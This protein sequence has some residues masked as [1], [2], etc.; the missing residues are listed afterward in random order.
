[1]S[2]T[3]TYINQW[4]SEDW[5]SNNYSVN[6]QLLHKVK[7]LF[8]SEPHVLSSM[9]APILSH[10]MGGRYQG[11]GLSIGLLFVSFFTLLNLF[12]LYK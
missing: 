5:G 6:D 8:L 7:I 11:K 3:T 9:H 2:N 4:L 12:K 1:M 10:L